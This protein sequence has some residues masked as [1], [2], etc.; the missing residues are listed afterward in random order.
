MGCGK[1]LLLE[2]HGTGVKLD[3]S[4]DVEVEVEKVVE[5]VDTSVSARIWNQWLANKSRVSFKR[6][7]E[8]SDDALNSMVQKLKHCKIQHTSPC[9]PSINDILGNE[10]VRA[11]LDPALPAFRNSGTKLSFSTNISTLK[12]N[13]GRPVDA[14]M[15][16][17]ASKKPMMDEIR[18]SGGLVEA[19]Q[20][21]SAKPKL[22]F[23]DS[24]VRDH[25]CSPIGGNASD[26]IVSTNEKR[27]F[28]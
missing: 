11:E 8:S 28:P 3:S 17:D 7:A 21:S 12:T 27:G 25:S 5:E 23:R 1:D 20:P 2:G 15:V 4:A 18:I 9:F 14:L 22:V 24:G 19:T 26:G 6:P 13:S 10:H 16:A